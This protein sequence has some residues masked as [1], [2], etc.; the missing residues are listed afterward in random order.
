MIVPSIRVLLVEDSPSDAQLLRI[1]LGMTTSVKFDVTH[2]ER[3]DEALA[4][5]RDGPFDVVLLDLS[6]P[7]SAGHNT[8]LRVQQQVPSMP[9]VVL[10]STSDEML[11]IQAVQHGLQDYLVKGQTDEHQIIR[12]IRYSLERKRAEEALRKAHDEL[13]RRVQERT[14]ELSAAIEMLRAEVARRALAEQSLRSRSDRLRILASELTLAEQRERKRLAKVLHDHLQQL[15]VG[16]KYQL[17][18]LRRSG[19]E[20]FDEM[21]KDLEATLDDSIAAC[22]SLTAGLNPPILHQAGLVPALEWLCRSMK[23]KHGLVVRLHAAEDLSM[24]RE[25]FRILLF[26][27]VRELLFNVAKH[28]GVHEA[29]V[30]LKHRGENFEV[31][32]SDKG[33]GFDPVKISARPVSKCGLGLYS[34]GE[35]L[36]LLGGKL[37]IEAAQGKGAFF[38]M[39]LPIDESEASAE[40]A[41]ISAAPGCVPGDGIMSST[42]EP[43]SK[44]RILLADDHAVMRQGLKLLLQQ[45]ADM[46][47]VAEASNGSAAVEAVR[48]YMP[49]VVLM[50]VS[51]PHLDGIKATRLIHTEFPAVKVIGVSMFAEADLASAMKDAGAVNY[52]AKSGPSDSVIA[53]I[54]DSVRETR[55]SGARHRVSRRPRHGSLTRT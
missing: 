34:I 9:V 2:V 14:A 23:E 37:E 31:T 6:L 39:T 20:D 55:R 43:T 17:A 13:E 38:R 1:Y 32:V 24:E 18:A 8:F 47:V 35:R 26:E 28:A 22:R 3:L 25:D 33:K 12:A 27:A 46:E 29:R 36:D 49:H 11:G 15:I 21:V 30:G 51:M 19:G 7:D 48:S 42:S 44:I 54:R 41:S 53:A 52:L 50:D 45:E 10:S 5:L 4:R 40:P 16:A